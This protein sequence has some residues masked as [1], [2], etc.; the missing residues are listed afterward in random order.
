M[1]IFL[2][3]NKIDLSKSYPDGTLNLKVDPHV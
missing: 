3:G 1:S 2:N